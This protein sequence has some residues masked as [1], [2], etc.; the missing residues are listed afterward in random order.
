MPSGPVSDGRAREL[1]T[2]GLWRR[3][4]DRWLE[5]MLSKALSDT[6]REWV[7]RRR[8]WCLAA[9]APAMEEDKLNVTDIRKA[10]KATQD[11]MGLSQPGGVAFRLNGK[12]RGD[13]GR[14]SDDDRTEEAM[15]EAECLIREYFQ[16]RTPAGFHR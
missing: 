6:Q 7:R 3:A 15:T 10:A 11:R 2:A 16:Q 1:E 5:V 8:K 13:D 12:R 9:A 14:V 4:A